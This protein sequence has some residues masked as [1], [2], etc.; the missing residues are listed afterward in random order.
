[1]S[2]NKKVETFYC[3][4][5][6]LPFS[7]YFLKASLIFMIFSFAAFSRSFLFADRAWMY[8]SDRREKLYLATSLFGLLPI[9]PNRNNPVFSSYVLY[10]WKKIIMTWYL[11]SYILYN[12][13]ALLY[14]LDLHYTFTLSFSSNTFEKSFRFSFLCLTFFI[15]PLS[16]SGGSPFCIVDFK[17]NVLTCLAS[18]FSILLAGDFKNE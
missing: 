4:V 18:T 9:S 1:M 8:F 7:R 5:W 17:D 3:K 10:Y 6:K 11:N 13:C 12:F 16:I 14:L 2:I 15:Q